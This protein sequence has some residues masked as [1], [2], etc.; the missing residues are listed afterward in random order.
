MNWGS[1]SQFHI[2]CCSGRFFHKLFHCPVLLYIQYTTLLTTWFFLRTFRYLATVLDI[3][4]MFT[5]SYLQYSCITAGSGRMPFQN[6]A[7][8]L[9]WLF[10][11]DCSCTSNDQGNSCIVTAGTWKM[12]FQYSTKILYYSF[13]NTAVFFSTTCKIPVLLQQEPAKYPFNTLQVSFISPFSI[14]LAAQF[15][16]YHCRNLQNIL[17]IPCKY[18][19]LPFKKHCSFPS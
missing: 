2:K 18:P 4:C 16:Y 3:S 17:S 15:L 12:S 8:I 11:K 10:L 1:I 13:W 6:P 7:K 9:Q 19:S 5:L 14:K